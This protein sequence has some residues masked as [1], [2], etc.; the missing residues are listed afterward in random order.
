MVLSNTLHTTVKSN[1]STKNIIIKMTGILKSK[2]F[3]EFNMK[4]P[5]KKYNPD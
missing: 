5:I 3:L 2:L 1:G 4:E